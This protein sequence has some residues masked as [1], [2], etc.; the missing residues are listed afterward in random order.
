[1]K[2]QDAMQPHQNGSETKPQQ[3][4]WSTINASTQ[5]NP[6]DNG[7]NAKT[8]YINDK[9]NRA[10]ASIDDNQA[11][12]STQPVP[13]NTN[14]D[15]TIPTQINRLLILTKRIEESRKLDREALFTNILRQHRSTSK[16]ID[17][18]K[19]EIKGT[20]GVVDCL[21]SQIKPS[22]RDHDDGGFSLSERIDEILDEVL[23]S[24]ASMEGLENR[25]VELRAAEKRELRGMREIVGRVGEDLGFLTSKL[26]QHED[27][28]PP[29]ERRMEKRIEGVEEKVMKIGEDLGYLTSE[30]VQDES[31][32]SPVQKRIEAVEGK[33]DEILKLLKEGRSGEKTGSRGFLFG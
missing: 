14:P 19:D 8:N 4:E 26:V 27:C 7:E 25:M 30:L 20:R 29:M 33:V 15:I 10:P 13:L 6:D 9:V 22:E 31:Q 5:C 18:L 32:K 12:L 21:H 17:D 24:E 23:G 28:K 1:M 3:S 16:K 2:N 11:P